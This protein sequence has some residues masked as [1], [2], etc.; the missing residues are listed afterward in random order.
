MKNILQSEVSM[1]DELSLCFPALVDKIT[2]KSE[3][4]MPCSV[5]LKR[6]ADNDL[7]LIKKRVSKF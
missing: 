4:T 3:L 1:E 5:A 7:K 6:L 2:K